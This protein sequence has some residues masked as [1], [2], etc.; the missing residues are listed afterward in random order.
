MFRELFETAPDAMIVVDRTGRI[1]RANPQVQ[2]LFGFPESE[3]LG[4]PIEK[5]MPEHV[6]HLH[7]SHVSGYTGNPR[8]R[9]MGTGQ[10]LTGQKKDGQQF[11]VEIALSPL[12][13]PEGRMFLASVR[14]VSE[15]QRARQ[16]IVRAR[17]DAC[18]A[19]IGQLALAAPNL[20][21]AIAGTPQIVAAA[22]GIEAVAILLR[23][24]QLK[25]MQARGAIGVRHD[26]IEALSWA[27]LLEQNRNQTF[28]SE[29]V[30]ANLGFHGCAII[31]LI[32][33]NEPA[34]ALIALSGRNH[35]EFDRDAMHFLQS[36]ANLMAAALQRIR[37]EEQ[38]SHAQRLEAIG[39]LTGGVAHDFN[40][41]LTVISG[42]LQILED[43]LADR[44]AAQQIIGT[45]LRAVGRGAELT[46]KLLAFARRQRLAPRACE[47]GKLLDDVGAMLRRTLG[48]SVQLQISCPAGIAPVYADPGQFEAALVNLA[49]NA[50]DAMPRGGLLSIGAAE[51]MIDDTQAMDDLKPGDYVVFT[52]RDTGL[53]MP[54]EILARALE[55]FFT[56]KEQGKGSGLGLSM[57]YGFIKQSGGRLTVESQ[58][59]YGTAIQMYLPAAAS[60]SVS[61][62]DTVARASSRG[63][64]TILVV[65]DEEDVRDIATAFLRSLGYAVRSAESAQ[66]AL[67]QL[68]AHADIAL[69]FS[70]VVL[71]TGMNGF[72]LADAARRLRTGLPV[73]LTSGYEH[74]AADSDAAQRFT[75]LQKPYRREE[76]AAAVR[77]I[78]DRR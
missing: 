4:E 76:L 68:G 1:V 19:Q 30:A 37:V 25:H 72:E 64:E 50:R 60:G 36:V 45:A 51:R 3:L 67:E 41:L 63:S 11:P 75:L 52:V 26:A 70:D 66:A 23:H 61:A 28:A 55:P 32:D 56:T 35:A 62:T 73:L 29:A 17:Y 22:L 34:G 39:Q 18:V 27:M 71:G 15:T 33:L 9:P 7:L 2:R 53:G 6:R 43:E 40:N 77:A 65:E 24:P 59:G 42:N 48:E 8:V 47:A 57:V 10:E 21:A 78:L 16:A 12:E 5:L 44:P 69:L 49:L 31:P 46:R 14:D 13:T 58:L 54:P 20:D 38:L 74:A